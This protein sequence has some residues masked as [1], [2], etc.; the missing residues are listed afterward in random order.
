MTADGAQ[1]NNTPTSKYKDKDY[2]RVTSAIRQLS[3]DD[4][5]A[6]WMIN[7]FKDY[8]E[9]LE[10]MRLSAER[11]SKVDQAIKDLLKGLELT[12]EQREPVKPYLDAFEKFLSTWGITGASFDEEVSDDEWK[13]VGT[14]DIFGD[15]KNG[16]LYPKAVIDI[17][18][19]HPLRNKDGSKKYEIF[20]EM[21]WQTAAYR[22]MKGAESN[23]I[24]RLFDDGEYRFEQD[25]N[26]AK[27]IQII[28]YATKI[29][30]LRKQR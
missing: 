6:R 5:L 11:G 10:S 30:H 25:P 18:T 12:P 20:E 23:W 21:H 13:L 9:Y 2:V 28:E 19:G 16:Q 7:S 4:R 22:K 29:A 8:D 17:K 1:L 3:K 26:Y 27:S 24:L 14:L 15:I